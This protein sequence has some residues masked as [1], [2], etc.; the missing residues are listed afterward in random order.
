MDNE[1]REIIVRQ[2]ALYR[3]LAPFI[4]PEKQEEFLQFV[5]QSIPAERA[6]NDTLEKIQK[7]K[8][9]LDKKVDHY[10]QKALSNKKQIQE[11]I[12]DTFQTSMKKR[13][14]DMEKTATKNKL[15]PAQKID[16]YNEFLLELQDMI[17][18][19]SQGNMSENFQEIRR[20]MIV[21]IMDEVWEKIITLESTVQK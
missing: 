8:V 15:T 16:F 21:Q 12:Q 5:S 7:S 19:L 14:K 11:S 13:L 17:A 20:D 1:K 10:N 2:S 4:A 18:G 9:A 6:K 3:E